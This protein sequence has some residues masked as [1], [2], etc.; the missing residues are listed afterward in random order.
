M[1]P[2]FGYKAGEFGHPQ[3][4]VKMHHSKITIA[5]AT[6]STHS[7]VYISISNENRAQNESLPDL[8]LFG[9]GWSG[10]VG[11][12]KANGQPVLLKA[13]AKCFGA[14]VDASHLGIHAEGP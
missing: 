8:S 6:P 5:L 10:R 13:D 2:A 9:R 1:I 12:P 7:N 4:N 3:Q 11:H 14:K